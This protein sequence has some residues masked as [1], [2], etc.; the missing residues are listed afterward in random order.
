MITI[1]HCTYGEPENAV[2]FNDEEAA[3]KYAKHYLKQWDIYNNDYQ[4]TV[5]ALSSIEDVQGLIEEE[6]IYTLQVYKVEMLD[7]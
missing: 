5:N 3:V 6:A 7:S 1:L 4:H 2:G